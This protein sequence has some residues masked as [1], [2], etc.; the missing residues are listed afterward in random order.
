MKWVPRDLSRQTR[1]SSRE[2]QT[3]SLRWRNT[4]NMQIRMKRISWNNTTSSLQSGNPVLEPR[5]SQGKLLYKGSNSLTR[6]YSNISW[7]WNKENSRNKSRNSEKSKY[8][9]GRRRFLNK[10]YR[11]NL[12]RELSRKAS[13]EFRRMLKSALSFSRISC[14]KNYFKTLIKRRIWHFPRTFL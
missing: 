1:R 11:R 13:G 7:S 12:N 9:R 8:S 3:N 6:S 10:K 14:M 2:G 4:P 5:K